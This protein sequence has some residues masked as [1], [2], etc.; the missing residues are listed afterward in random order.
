[1]LRKFLQLHKNND[2]VE[3]VHLL[4]VK[5][6]YTSIRYSDGREGNVSVS[7]LSPC[8]RKSIQSS[9]SNDEP[10]DLLAAEETS[11]ASQDVNDG[12]S[13][14]LPSGDASLQYSEPV[15]QNNRVLRRLTR[16]NE[17]VP[18]LRFGHAFSH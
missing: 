13:I 12:S 17:G 16:S 15:N 7:N 1:M 18:P 10:E 4:D 2:L 11:M 9:Q 6:S 5:P 8:P 3:E 14:D